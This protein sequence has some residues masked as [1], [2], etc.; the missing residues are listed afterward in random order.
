[1]LCSAEVTHMFAK[2]LGGRCHDKYGAAD[3]LMLYDCACDKLEFCLSEKLLNAEPIA[4]DGDPVMT[5]LQGLLQEEAPLTLSKNVIAGSMAQ[6]PVLNSL[7]VNI[8]KGLPKEKLG[9]LG[10]DIFLSHRCLRAWRY[11]EPSL[12]SCQVLCAHKIWWL[13]CS[14]IAK[15]VSRTVMYIK[16][17]HRTT[18]TPVCK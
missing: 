10:G 16:A 8:L 14:C 2:A 4:G 6:S 1:M 13:K 11:R 15:G 9:I 17:S 18:S 7:P 5:Q 3:T 12:K